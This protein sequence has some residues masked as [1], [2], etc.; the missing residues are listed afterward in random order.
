MKQEKDA[1]TISQVHMASLATTS[2]VHGE[3]YPVTV[4]TG[5][6]NG[7][8]FNPA[9]PSLVGFPEVVLEE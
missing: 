6:E 9:L 1:V 3:E 5:V 7:W 8:E 2:Q 4:T